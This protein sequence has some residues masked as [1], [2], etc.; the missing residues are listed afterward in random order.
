M[1]Y[2][3]LID[4]SQPVADDS[5]AYPGDAPFQ[6]ELTLNYAESKIVNLTKFS[7]SPHVG[8]HVDAP[9]HIKGDMTSPADL[10]GN[11]PLQPFIGPAIV[12]NVSGRTGAI[13]WSAVEDRLTELTN[14]PERVLFRTQ[15]KVRYNVF[16]SEYS[17]L[18]PE[19]VSK[20]AECGVKLL[21][22]DAPSVDQ[23][24]SK[25]LEVHHEMD[26]LGMVWLENLDLSQVR[27]GEFFLIAFPIK[28]MEL[29]ASPVRAV[30]LEF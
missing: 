2:K 19:L 21:G 12:I 25:T 26:R 3:R 6:R 30:L 13:S 11:L 22:I 8:T 29:E 23:I 14:L 7:M 18:T 4:I 5:A 20:L 10:A 9:A 24:G 15:E 16:E 27:S 28:F 17:F 1:H